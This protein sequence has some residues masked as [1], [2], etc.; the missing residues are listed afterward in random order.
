VKLN[1]QIHGDALSTSG[2]NPAVNL[3]SNGAVSGDICEGA[4]CH[5]HTLNAEPDWTTTCAGPSQGNLIISSNQD[6]AS[7]PALGNQCWE[8]L[9]IQ[10]GRTLT[11]TD[12][13]NPYRFKTIYWED[14]SS[15]I[16]T[17]PTLP[18]DEKVTIYVDNFIPSE[19][20][21][22]V[23]NNNNNAPR[24]LEINV[25]STSSFKIK[26]SAE[27]RARIKAR[28]ADIELF[29]NLTFHGAIE[30]SQLLIKDN[31][32]FNYDEGIGEGIIPPA[33]TL[34]DMTFSLKKASQRYR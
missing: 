23:L 2:S 10:S 25:T 33:P 20:T 29:E 21:G 19:F 30:S 13:D 9:T 1:S 34:S 27:V 28:N 15:S 32:V 26:G 18:A 6:L 11:L 12:T 5:T 7:G 3:L 24:T 4:G 8:V 14:S 31:V 16:L 22:V 17:F